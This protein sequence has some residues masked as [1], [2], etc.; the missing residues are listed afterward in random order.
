M[1]KQ[2]LKALNFDE[3]ERFVEGVGWPRY[4]ADQILHWIYRQGVTQFE[5]MTDLSLPDR[6]SL[7]ERAY[8][9]Q[10]KIMNAQTSTDG[11]LKFLLMLEDSNTIESVLIPDDPSSTSSSASGGLGGRSG[12]R[13]TLC[14]STQVGCTLDCSFCLTGRMGLRRNLTAHEI[15][16]QVLSVQSYVGARADETKQ[17]PPMPPHPALSALGGLA[18]PDPRFSHVEDRE[19]GQ[20]IT[21]IV[22]MGM[23]EPL[24][25]FNQVVEAIHRI[26]SPRGIGFPQRRITLSTAGL[27]PQ[28]RTLGTLGLKINLAISLNATTDETRDLIMGTINRKYPIKELIRACRE[29]PLPP[30]RRITFEYVLIKGV[31]DSILDAQRVVKLLKGIRCKVNLIPYNE[32]PGADFKRPTDQAVLQFQQVLV[33]T[34]LNAFIRKSKGQDILAA[35]GQLATATNTHRESRLSSL[36]SAS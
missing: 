2:N 18:E 12:R 19:G 29:Y 34:H 8:I 35:C 16:D 7:E 10:L 6:R 14:I 24:A 26:S 30:R 28:I 1:A 33:D 13:L 5:G 21:N 27:V 32:H 17:G 31:N 4:R 15:V 22:M 20:R 3:L 36:S 25:N 11:T 9:R 23:G